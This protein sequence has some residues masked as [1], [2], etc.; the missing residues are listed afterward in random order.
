MNPIAKTAYYCCGVR[1]QDMT[2]H[3]PLCG[4]AL[5]TVFMDDEAR[6]TF[7]PFAGLRGPNLTTVVRH[8]MIDDLLRVH[9]AN[10][11]ER[12]VLLLG[13]GFDTRP[14]RL[15][16]G[17][18]LELDQEALLNRKNSVL[19]PDRAPNPLRRVSIDFARDHLEEK[20]GDWVG[21][22]DAVVVI[23]G[24]S[25]YLTQ[26]H[27]TQTLAT[28]RRCLPAHVLICDL[29]TKRFAHHYSH[30]LLQ[31]IRK[32]GG[33]FSEMIDNPGDTVISAGFVETDQWSIVGQTVALGAMTIPPIVLNT[34]LRGLRDG[35]RVHRF[36][37]EVC[38]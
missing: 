38:G 30:A 3:M 16:G 24:I 6:R 25:M 14:F 9:L 28:L 20:I 18:W 15:E 33:D 5:A 31:R 35:Y 23:E 22:P 11:P 26:T 21:T 29:M 10:Q 12:R 34:V 1:M 13:A 2:R 8:R 37:A 7:A 19:P 4:D 32:L 27:L 17:E 36:V